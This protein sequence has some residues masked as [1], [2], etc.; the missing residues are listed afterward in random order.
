MQEEIKR[1]E[2]VISALQSRLDAFE[3]EEK[4]RH[5][6]ALIGVFGDHLFAAAAKDPVLAGIL[7]SN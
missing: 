1:L 3:A 7:V 4:R 6:L 2:E 5:K